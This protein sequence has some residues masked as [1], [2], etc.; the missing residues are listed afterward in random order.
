MRL[1]CEEQYLDVAR[2]TVLE[3]IADPNLQ[4]MAGPGYPGAVASLLILPGKDFG[5]PLD[6]PGQM[7][8]T[9]GFR[10]MPTG[11]DYDRKQRVALNRAQC[12]ELACSLLNAA[13]Q[14]FELDDEWE[15]E[16]PAA[17]VFASF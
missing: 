7:S 6:L 2:D 15:I 13:G 8:S 11:L 4:R 3:V 5:P 1:A 14:G 17:D 9:P 12:V 10:A 16:E